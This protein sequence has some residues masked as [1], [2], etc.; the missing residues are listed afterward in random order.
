MGW[1][2]GSGRGGGPGRLIGAGKGVGDRRVPQRLC[3]V[4]PQAST[5]GTITS[6]K[7]GFIADYIQENGSYGELR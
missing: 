4:L 3:A 1:E 5:S 6:I 7:L 2:A